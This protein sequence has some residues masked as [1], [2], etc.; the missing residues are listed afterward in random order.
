MERNRSIKLGFIGLTVLLAAL[1]S[2]CGPAANNVNQA[3]NANA[4]TGA[5]ASNTSNANAADTCNDDKVNKDILAKVKANY[6]KEFR[7]QVNWYSKNCKVELIGWVELPKDGNPETEK[8][9]QD[10]KDLV[11]MTP[12]VKDL[13]PDPDKGFK[14]YPG[15]LRDENKLK[16][17]RKAAL[18]YECDG[19]YIRCGDICVP[20]GTCSNDC[21][22]PDYCGSSMIP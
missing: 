6:P 21:L 15:Q 13:D 5:N 18:R 8:R 19:N 3:N 9:F 17:V 7:R 2:A 22:A 14:R 4:T 16:P 20:P 1:F 10:F 11:L 12:E